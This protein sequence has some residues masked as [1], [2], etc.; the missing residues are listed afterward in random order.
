MQ[1]KTETLKPTR[2]I[3]N[4][5]DPTCEKV[6]GRDSAF[7]Y[8]S[9]YLIAIGTAGI[10]ACVPTHGADQ[11]D[12]DNPKEAKSLSAYFNWLL[13]AASIGA[14]VSLI[15]IVWIQTDVGWGWG[16]GVSL[17]GMFIGTIIFVIGTPRYRV[18]AVQKTDPICSVVK[19]CGPLRTD[20]SL[21][22]SLVQGILISLATSCFR[23]L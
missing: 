16:F 3:N 12:E 17:I 23:F 4:P 20:I 14:T 15:L 11:F 10:K 19:V 13:L 7:L 1:A 18:H 5:F 22:I 9:I 8:I 21:F 2:C 6:H